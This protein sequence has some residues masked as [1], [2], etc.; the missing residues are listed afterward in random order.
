MSTSASDIL[1]FLQDWTNSKRMLME[2]RL[3]DKN[4]NA[5]GNLRAS[6][7]WKVRTTPTSVEMIL[8][9]ADYWAYIDMGVEGTQSGSS[10]GGFKFK[11]EFPNTKM[12]GSIQEWIAYKGIGIRQS[13]EQSTESVISAARKVAAGMSVSIKRKGIKATMFFSDNI[14]EAAFADLT[15]A[16]MEQFGRKVFTQLP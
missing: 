15:E 5:T 9:A 4:S 1:E 11:T 16:V 8:E 7:F 3:D 12:I 2:N 6:L 10:L 14:N 13:R